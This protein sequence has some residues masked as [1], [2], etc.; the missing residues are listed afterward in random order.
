MRRNVH[1]KPG[2]GQS[3][4]GMIVGLL[5]CGLGLVVVIPIFGA[6]GIV[7]T[8]VAVAITV[9]NG[10]NA[11]SD[12]GITSHE[13]IVDEYDDSDMDEGAK[14]PSAGTVRDRLN[15]IQRLYDD[16]TITKEEY[17]EK[18]RQILDEI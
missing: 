3:M 7:W 11:F 9:V 5:F 15:T 12:R 8:L 18:R 6:F 1:V 2:K 17:E 10:I 4:I 13:I 14:N 16:G